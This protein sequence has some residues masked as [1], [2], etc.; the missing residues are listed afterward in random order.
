MGNKIITRTSATLII[1]KSL[2][3][4]TNDYLLKN[5]TKKLERECAYPL[6]QNK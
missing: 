5:K 6:G 3:K 2:L 1:T 4:K